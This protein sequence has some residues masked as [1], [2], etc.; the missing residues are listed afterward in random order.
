MLIIGVV[1]TSR[2]KTISIKWSSSHWSA[3]QSGDI[4]NELVVAA[5]DDKQLEQDLNE[6]LETLCGVIEEMS[7]PEQRPPLR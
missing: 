7:E 1:Q 3:R 2:G 6:L 5:P 4:L